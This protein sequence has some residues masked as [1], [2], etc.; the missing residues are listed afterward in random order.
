MRVELKV[1]VVKDD[2]AAWDFDSEYALE[3][4]FGLPHALDDFGD[5]ALETLVCAESKAIHRA[6]SGMRRVRK[7]VK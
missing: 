3:S 1:R 4:M 5:Y 7:K 6:K 2:G